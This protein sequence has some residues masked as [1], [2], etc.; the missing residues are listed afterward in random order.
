[1]TERERMRAQARERRSAISI[2]EVAELSARIAERVLHHPGYQAARAV[3]AYAGMQDEVRTDGLAREILRSGR[4][5]Y[6][7]VTGED[8]RMWPARL[9]ELS[10]VRKGRFGILEPLDPTPANPLEM[11]LILV[12]GLA[13]D[14][15]GN[16]LGYGGGYYDRFLPQC[17][18]LKVGLAFEVQ[19][20][21]AV[22][23]ERH[24]VPM[25]YLITERAVYDCAAGRSPTRRL[26]D[27][28]K[29]VE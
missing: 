19:L 12:P 4:A 13:F 21:E 22:P 16:R 11:D 15:V 8:R 6:L 1:M 18:G 9:L 29:D 20:M 7:P 23:V 27:E 5:L 28:E 25:D 17:T 14:R 26:P 2:I 10:R 24:D 3:M